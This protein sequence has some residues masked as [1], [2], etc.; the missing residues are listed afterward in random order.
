MNIETAFP[1]KYLK[2]SDIPTG[3]TVR[4]KIA[5]FEEGVKFGE[6]LRP[7]VGFH[8]TDKSLVLNKTNANRI[9]MTVAREIGKEAAKE[10]DNWIGQDIE[11]Y[12]E[13]V[14]YQGRLTE[15]VRVRVPSGPAPAQAAPVNT[16]HPLNAPPPASE[17]DYGAIL[18]DEVPF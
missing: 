4:L 2:A 14:E 15:A 1:S 18:D 6:D 16:G 3:K 17:A 13:M 12:S 7:V 11:L 8:K 9:Y 10:T 5:S